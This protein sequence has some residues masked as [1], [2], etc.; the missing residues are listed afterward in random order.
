MKI[1][2]LTANFRLSTCAR[3]SFFRARSWEP[4]N[5]SSLAEYASLDSLSEIPSDTSA[6]L[7]SA[8]R[9]HSSGEGRE[10]NFHPEDVT[11]RCDRSLYLQHDRELGF[12]S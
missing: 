11:Q 4:V 6:T 8:F 7:I 2:L 12:E 3:F 10:E 1:F 5:L 9:A